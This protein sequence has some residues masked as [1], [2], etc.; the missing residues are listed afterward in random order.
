MELAAFFLAISALSHA[1]DVLDVEEDVV[2]GI[3]TPAVEMR[4]LEAEHYAIALSLA[5][6]LL[7]AQQGA[8]AD[9]CVFLLA[10]T[11]G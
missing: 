3:R 7:Y 8:S 2:A 6:A 10:A 9:V 11:R 1:A 4:G 5:S